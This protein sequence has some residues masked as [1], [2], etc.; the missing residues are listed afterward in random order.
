[1]DI[2]EIIIRLLLTYIICQIGI[3]HVWNKAFQ[4]GVESVKINIVINGNKFG[5]LE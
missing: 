3:S 5:K 4:K 2:L 1:M